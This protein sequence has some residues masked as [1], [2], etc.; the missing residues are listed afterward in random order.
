MEATALSDVCCFQDSQQQEMEK[1][2]PAKPHLVRLAVYLI[3]RSLIAELLVFNDE[4][5]THRL[6]RLTADDLLQTFYSY[7]CYEGI[8]ASMQC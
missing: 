7:E 6:Q 1:G 2:G 8:E 5:L 4:W 3:M